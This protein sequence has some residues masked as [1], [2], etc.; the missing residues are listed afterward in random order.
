MA[1]DQ[2]SINSSAATVAGGSDKFSTWIQS[3]V[4]MIGKI[5]SELMEDCLKIKQ[6]IESA[7]EKIERHRN[8]RENLEG[9]LSGSVDDYLNVYD[10]QI[11]Q[12]QLQ[13][14]SDRRKWEGKLK[15]QKRCY[16]AVEKSIQESFKVL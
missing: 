12:M 11:E 5:E 15:N 14:G 2:Y 1:Q 13:F 7:R 10:K 4:E 3:K 9:C 8:T 16:E 6:M